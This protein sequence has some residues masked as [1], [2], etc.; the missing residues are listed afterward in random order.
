MP[1]YQLSPACKN[2]IWGGHHRLR[3]DYGVS[4]SLDPLAEAWVL[5]CHPAGPSI[6]QTG[7]FA[8]LT[9]SEYIAQA[10]WQVL[11]T[12]CAQFKEFPLLIKLINAQQ[13]TSVQVHPPDEYA[14]VHEGQA[15][16]TEMWVVLHAEP[17]AFLYYGLNRSV[18][19]EELARR[20]TNGTLTEILRKVATKAGDTFFIPAGTIHAIG[21]GLTLAEIQ[22]N[23]NVTYRLFDYGRAGADGK[24]RLLHIDKALSVASLSPNRQQDFAPHLGQCG[25]FTVDRYYGTFRGVCGNETFHAVLNISGMGKLF[26]DEEQRD[27]YPGSC[28]FLP[29]DSGTYAVEGNCKTLVVYIS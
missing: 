4:S 24:T 3:E 1:A 8:G 7:P 11:G 22:Q 10:G 16:K 21:P 26:C 15:G 19:R 17:D 9:L 18:S 14:L 20:I 2:Y 27:L 25:Y 12:R 29:A 6:L 13:A 28:Y 23:S 5:S